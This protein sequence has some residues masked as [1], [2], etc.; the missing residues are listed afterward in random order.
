MTTEYGVFNDEGCLEAGMWSQAQADERAAEY[1]AEGDD[2]A[3]AHELCPEH[4]GRN[5][6]GTDPEPKGGCEPCAEAETED[7]GC[8]AMDPDDLDACGDCDDCTGETAKRL[9]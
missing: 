3:K 5:G 6:D 1:R 8:G 2:E 4:D 7:E 9:G